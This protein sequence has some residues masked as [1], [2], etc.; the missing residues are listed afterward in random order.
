MSALDTLHSASMPQALIAHSFLPVSGAISGPLATY[1]DKF[2]LP[3][4]ISIMIS[5][6]T[7]PRIRIGMGTVAVHNTS[8]AATAAT[9]CTAVGRDCSTPAG[10]ACAVLDAVPKFEDVANSALASSN[11]LA[12]LAML[13]Q[14]KSAQAWAKARLN[15]GI[16]GTVNF[17]G[18]QVNYTVGTSSQGCHLHLQLASKPDLMSAMK[19]PA[20]S[21]QGVPATLSAQVSAIQ[22]GFKIE[23]ASLE[24][25]T[26]PPCLQLSG[27]VASGTT[28]SK[29]EFEA[30]QDSVSKSWAYDVAVE[31]DVGAFLYEKFRSY[32]KSAPD[33]FKGLTLPSTPPAL[34]N[35]VG[36]LSYNTSTKKVNFGVG[37]A[38]GNFG[39]PGGG[40]PLYNS[41]LV[42]ANFPR[43]FS[44]GIYFP[45]VRNKGEKDAVSVFVNWA[46]ATMYFSLSKLTLEDNEQTFQAAM[47]KAT[48]G[49]G[50]LGS[51]SAKGPS[52]FRPILQKFDQAKIEY[53][54]SNVQMD[55]AT[56]KGQVHLQVVAKVGSQPVEA[57]LVCSQGDNNQWDLMVHF[58]AA[59][60]L[61]EEVGKSLPFLDLSRRRLRVGNSGCADGS[62]EATFATNAHGCSSHW[63]P[64]AG[65]VAG[66]TACA[67]GWHVCRGVDDALMS[68]INTT[69]CDKG[70]PLGT[71]FATLA[72]GTT[73]S[74]GSVDCNLPGF[75]DIWGC[76]TASAALS[77]KTT[78]CGVL[79]K[80][81]GHSAAKGWNTAAW[82]SLHDSQGG[83]EMR[84]VKKEMGNGGVICCRDT[85]DDSTAI[86]IRR[87]K[88]KGTLD[89]TMGRFFFSDFGPVTT[90]SAY[91]SISADLDQLHQVRPLR[92]YFANERVDVYARG[93]MSG[94]NTENHAHGLMLYIKHDGGF[95]LADIAK[96]VVGLGKECANP[97]QSLFCQMLDTILAVRLGKI[98]LEAA[99]TNSAEFGGCCKNDVILSVS[100]VSIAGLPP[101][102][103]TFAAQYM[104]LDATWSYGLRLKWK[105]FKIGDILGKLD[106]LGGN[107]CDI[108]LF[109]PL[110]DIKIN[111]PAIV[112][113]TGTPQQ[114]NAGADGRRHLS[115][116]LVGG[117]SVCENLMG[118]PPLL[119]AVAC[120]VSQLQSPLV[121]S[122]TFSS[123][124]IKF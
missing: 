50:S 94:A 107:P 101:V 6:T 1:L 71:F 116:A 51:A 19:A 111:E 62:T 17:A 86:Q 2:T 87:D 73:Q 64:A 34:Q 77:L 72:A 59:K 122:Q 37:S 30:R 47:S 53:M 8:Q 41:S 10:C 16:N 98:Q 103:A 23:K 100:K 113:S 67:D 75:D 91:P 81:L 99:V 40:L 58:D 74:N 112:Y 124:K 123:L 29:I 82:K 9:K 69:S 31:S 22:N 68:G 63:A 27:V 119:G 109:K 12:Q 39:T 57:E 54:G 106:A 97:K 102:N 20:M 84:S 95:T 70:A 21:V 42:P 92:Y 60:F 26:H 36:R 117:A 105:S 49:D 15:D 89:V 108:P 83:N 24:A 48:A 80:A 13:N 65:V 79:T 14:V 11:Q 46:N 38:S 96:E 43:G 35:L 52:Q 3:N 28:R 66:K 55:P 5:S 104:P 114:H 33:V 56:S 78:P 32:I 118:L 76:G 121:H 120:G 115:E 44:E 4:S 7:T 45:P 61:K 90:A 25:W 93:R 18:A 85:Q 110:C 88:Q